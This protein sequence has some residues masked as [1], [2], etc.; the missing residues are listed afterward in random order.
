M[1]NVADLCDLLDRHFPPDTA[2]SWDS[3]GLICGDP[4]ATVSRVLFGLDPTIAVIHE[5]I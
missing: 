4:A 2:D 3:V 5:A 1:P